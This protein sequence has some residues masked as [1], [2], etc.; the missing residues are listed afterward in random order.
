MGLKSISKWC[1]R[2]VCR[3]LL[4][5]YPANG[6]DSLMVVSNRRDKLPRD[7]VAVMPFGTMN[8]HQKQTTINL[9]K[10]N[11]R[12]RTKGVVRWARLAGS[13]AGTWKCIVKEEERRRVGDRLGTKR[14]SQ[15]NR[16]TICSD[17]RKEKLPTYWAPQRATGDFGSFWGNKTS[18]SSRALAP[19]PAKQKRLART[20]KK[21]MHLLPPCLVLQTR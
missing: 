20:K 21:K 8:Q 1:C 3:C 14:S 12:E 2:G 19:S 7:C 6:R 15:S 18:L 9:Y 10:F 16:V 5:Q 4:R 13:R 11:R 17:Q